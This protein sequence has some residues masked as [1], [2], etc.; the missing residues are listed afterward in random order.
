M[1]CDMCGKEVELKKTFV[2][3]TTMQL[4][5]SCQQYGTVE[6]TKRTFKK[7]FVEQEERIVSSYAQKIKAAREQKALKQ[8]QLAQQV[9]IKLSQ[10]H[11]F[12]SANHEPDID[13]AKKLEK[14][15][16]ITLVTK[17]QIDATTSTTKSGPMTIG[18][19]LK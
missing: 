13:T 15:L 5:S 17:E 10:L 14:A 2:E 11:K 4:R 3:G 8:E 12:E 1:A 16:N 7:S 18:D 19:L 6:K 9:G